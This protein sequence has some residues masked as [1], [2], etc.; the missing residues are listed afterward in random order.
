MYLSDFFLIQISWSAGKCSSAELYPFP[1]YWLYP[2]HLWGAK[3]GC[4]QGKECVSYP[5]PNIWGHICCYS[6]GGTVI[7][8]PPKT[9]YQQKLHR[10]R[11]DVYATSQKAPL[12]K[13]HDQRPGL[14][15]GLNT[16]KTTFGMKLSKG[17]SNKDVCHLKTL[18]DFM[19][20]RTPCHEFSMNVVFYSCE[21]IQ[22]WQLTS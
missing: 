14:P 3:F 17:E 21:Y 16:D 7:N 12:G 8:P 5:Q 4:M 11:E 22:A 18:P 19:T 20:W 13:S 2:V 1:M 9:I 6:Q 10:F 15:Y